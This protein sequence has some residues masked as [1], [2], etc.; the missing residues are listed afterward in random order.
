MKN[1]LKEILI[2]CLPRG[3]P[4]VEDFSLLLL[5]EKQLKEIEEEPLLPIFFFFFSHHFLPSTFQSWP[6]FTVKNQLVSGD[7]TT[8]FSLSNHF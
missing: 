8:N 1:P 2:G 6:L 3:W 5:E 4:L 7:G